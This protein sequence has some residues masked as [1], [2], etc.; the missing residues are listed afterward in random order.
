MS[1]D[2]HY[3]AI[4]VGSGFGGSVTA[5]RL[6]E[7]GKRVLVLERGRPYPPGSFTRSP[8][9]A[10]ESFWDPPRGL[11]GMYHYWSFKGIDALVSA[12]L[13]GGSL[14]YANVFI[15]KDE[16]WF[17]HEDMSDGGYEYWP[18]NREDLDPHYDRVEQMLN[19]QRYPFD[20]EPYAST[21]KTIAFKEAAEANGLE[22]F[23]PQLAVTFANKDRPPVP[24]EVIQED[25]VNLHGRTRTTCQLCGECDVGC[26]YGAK[27][28]LDYNY[29]THAKHHG[30]EI[31]TLADVRRIG[32]RAT[33][34]GYEVV[35]ADLGEHPEQPTT[36]ELTCDHLIL[37]AGT[38]GTTNLLLKN[39][40][41]FPGLSRKLGSRF[42]GNGDLL[43]LALNTTKVTDGVREPR[44]VDPGYGPVITS[45]A[46]MPDASDPG[47]SGRGF[48]LQDAGFP[49]HLAWILHVISAPKQLW[50]WREGAT[51][52]LKNWIQGTP[53][54]EVTGH[55][56]DLMLPSELS[57]G[58][59]PLLGMGRDV[60]D[61]RMY[62]RNG[63]LDIDWR[64]ASGSDEY[65]NRLRNTS[66]DFATA[67]GGRFADN[68]LWFLKRVITVHPLGGA[69]M[70]RHAGE[71]V[72]DAYG[73]VF[74]HPGLHIADGSVMPGPTGP[75]PSFTIAALADRFA[76]Q[77]IDPD[78]RAAEAAAS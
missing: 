20:H 45:T 18:V 38:L 44:I 40:S 46:R 60:P 9:R 11:V 70:G 12:G 6:A 69:P 32:P 35:Y 2:S 42:C 39:R 37:S 4:I 75:N 53:D 43:T 49:Q 3:D 15:R 29:L 13:G 28:T 58:G 25:L 64:K 51:Y 31:R 76:D 62:L 59:L 30:A 16:N 41:A 1:L 36:F 50:R 10:R 17:V 63:H 54:S 77:I 48:Y 33:G 73:N 26:N 65:F 14:I 34:N 72:V 24:G 71:G 21:P 66:R 55:I 78:R 57:S 68:P 5:Y 22:W 67:L 56:A 23:L 7:A 8:Y 19:L 47:G 74:G 27:N 52:L 61:G